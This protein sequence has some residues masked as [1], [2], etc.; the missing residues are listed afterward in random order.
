MTKKLIDGVQNPTKI[1]ALKR[2]L[3]SCFSAE[4]SGFSGNSFNFV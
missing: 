3:V 2:V 1:K 4:H